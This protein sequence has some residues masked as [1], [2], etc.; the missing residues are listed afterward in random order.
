M[1]HPMEAL[2]RLDSNVIS[3]LKLLEEGGSTGL[4]T[5]L[6]KQFSLET[7]LQVDKIKRALKANDLKTVS[8]TGHYLK[9]S[10]SSLG[11]KRFAALCYEVE[12]LPSLQEKDKVTALITSLETEL[13]ALLPELKKA[14]S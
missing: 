4:L 10:A 5:R 3:E 6:L 13:A 12:K 11:A 7:P 14:L 8:E 9:S 2:P 1:V